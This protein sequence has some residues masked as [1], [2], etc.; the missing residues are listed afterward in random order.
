LLLVNAH[1]LE[2]KISKR[3]LYQANSNSEAASPGPVSRY[4]EDIIDCDREERHRHMK[5]WQPPLPLFEA[6]ISRSQSTSFKRGRPLERALSRSRESVPPVMS[7]IALIPLFHLQR[8]LS[9]KSK[10][11]FQ[12]T[13]KSTYFRRAHSTP[14]PKDFSS[15]NPIQPPSRLP[16]AQQRSATPYGESSS[17]RYDL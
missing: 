6:E 3:R 1:A 16:K 7:P 12:S 2:E 5:V 14:H 13:E 10:C 11:S 15:V 17:F 9:Q 4:I 8:E